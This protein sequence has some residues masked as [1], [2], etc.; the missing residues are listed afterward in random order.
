[1]HHVTIELGKFEGPNT[2]DS[3]LGGSF[4]ARSWQIFFKLLGTKL[5]DFLYVGLD[6]CITDLFL[7]EV[8]NGIS[9]PLLVTAIFMVSVICI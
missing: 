5:D 3:H 8:F 6:A 4:K 1:M 9:M 7:E 2:W